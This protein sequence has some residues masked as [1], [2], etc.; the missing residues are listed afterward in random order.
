MNHLYRERNYVLVRFRETGKQKTRAVG[1]FVFR[2][3]IGECGVNAEVVQLGVAR[4][5]RSHWETCCP[6]IQLHRQYACKPW[7][8]MPKPLVKV[9]G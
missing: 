5:G 8:S 1:L 7:R 2:K 6:C 4:L 9:L 3:Y